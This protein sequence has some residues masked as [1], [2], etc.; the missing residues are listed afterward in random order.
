MPAYRE[1]DEAKKAE[2]M[3]KFGTE[4]MPNTMAILEKLLTKNGGKYFVGK[5]V[6]WADIEVAN[7]PLNK[8]N[9]AE[10][11]EAANTAWMLSGDA[12]WM[13]SGGSRKNNPRGA[14]DMESKDLQVVQSLACS[15]LDK[16]IKMYLLKP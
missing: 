2:L 16:W 14:S 9:A 11:L 1:Q 12:G 5:N 3:K 15:A 7:K 6:T 4:T 8:K 10:N 13:L